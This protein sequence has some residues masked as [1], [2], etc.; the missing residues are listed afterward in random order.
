MLTSTAVKGFV[1]KSGL[2]IL[3]TTTGSLRT[4]ASG[5]VYGASFAPDG[6]DRIVFGRPARRASPRP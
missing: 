5:I 3:D 4:I 6:S 1:K 2:G